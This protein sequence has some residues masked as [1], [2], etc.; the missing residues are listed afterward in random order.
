MNSQN[1]EAGYGSKNSSCAAMEW[2]HWINIAAA[3]Q[4]Y[5]ENKIHKLSII[6]IFVSS[7]I[8]ETL[9]ECIAYSHALE[10]FKGHYLKPINKIFT[11]HRL[12]T[13]KQNSDKSFNEYLQSYKV[14]A[15]ECDFTTV[16][17][18]IAAMTTSET[19]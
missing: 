10:I 3:L 2:T 1:C 16:A 7:R 19:R 14:L 13:R 18:K 12:D 6:T 5:S 8:Y 9:Y 11:K 17:G 15:K 4:R